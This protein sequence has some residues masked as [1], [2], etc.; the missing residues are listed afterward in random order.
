MNTTTK[1]FTGLAALALAGS[2][3]AN[4]YYITG[5]SAFRSATHQAIIAAMGGSAN[6]KWASD[7]AL[8]GASQA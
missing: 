8:D 5:S 1:I 4:T 3:F 6:V 7:G 2:A